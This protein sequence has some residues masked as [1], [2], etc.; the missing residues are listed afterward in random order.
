MLHGTSE[1]SGYPFNGTTEHEDSAQEFLSAESCR[2]VRGVASRKRNAS[3]AGLFILPLRRLLPEGTYRGRDRA[4]CW[5]GREKWLLHCSVLYCLHYRRLRHEGRTEPVARET[6]MM[7]MAGMSHGADNQTG[8]DCRVPVGKLHRDGARSGLVSHAEVCRRQVQRARHLARELGVITDVQPGRLRTLAE[9]LQSWKRGDRARGWCTVSVLHESRRFS[10]HPVDNRNGPH[11]QNYMDVTPLIRSIGR[12]E[13]P[14]MGVVTQ[15]TSCRIKQ[16]DTR[17]GRTQA[18]PAALRLARGCLNHRKMPPWIRRHGKFAWA[19]VLAPFAAA[20]WD[21]DDVAEALREYAIGHYVLP[22]PQ[23]ALGYL[24]SILNTFDLHNRPAT[25]IRAEA[26]ARDTERRAKQKQLRAEWATR[27]ANAAR[28][29]SPGRQAVRQ[30]LEE[31]RKRP[32][33]FR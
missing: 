15:G 19:R 30:A 8:R 24:R 18:D 23:N 29:D 4:Q 10:R 32:K 27:N 11:L 33:K 20:A 3:R 17:R 16:L 5:W 28:E 12:R 14:R 9:R 21:A 7:V 13:N 1:G 26:A 25:L 31:I 22:N 2:P 6:F